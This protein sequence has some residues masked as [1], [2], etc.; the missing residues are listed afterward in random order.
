MTGLLTVLVF[1]A[2]AVLVIWL[3]LAGPLGR[4][5]DL[6]LTPSGRRRARPETRQ[7]R[8]VY[9]IA[10]VGRGAPVSTVDGRPTGLTIEPVGMV[11]PE[12]PIDPGGMV[13]AAGHAMV[14]SKAVAAA[15]QTPAY[16]ASAAS[17]AAQAASGTPLAEE[18]ALL[19]D[20]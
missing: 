10:R 4:D 20:D 13:P 15:E 8:R 7:R 5:L 14:E 18:A 19:H 17:P 1:L 12:V 11:V 3:L 16:R 2:P 9:R 6:R